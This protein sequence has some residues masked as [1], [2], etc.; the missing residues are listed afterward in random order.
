MKEY[1][2]LWMILGLIMVGSFTLLGYFG[3]EIYNE[4]P[5]IC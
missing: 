2:R 3:K 5:P 4:R 1:K